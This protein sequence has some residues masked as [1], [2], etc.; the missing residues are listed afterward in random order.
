MKIAH[1]FFIITMIYS[2][3]PTYCYA[4]QTEQEGLD[5]Y[6][7]KFDECSCYKTSQKRN[8]CLTEL[9]KEYK[10]GKSEMK[11][12]SYTEQGSDE[13]DAR[14]TIELSSAFPLFQFYLIANVF[15]RD[16]DA[17]FLNKENELIDEPN[18]R[19]V[20]T[21][22]SYEDL[23]NGFVIWY[24]SL[25]EE[26]KIR[27]GTYYYNI[28]DSKREMYEIVKKYSKSETKEEIQKDNLEANKTIKALILSLQECIDKENVR[29]A[30]ETM[31]NN[32]DKCTCKLKSASLPLQGKFFYLTAF[33][34]QLYLDHTISDKSNPKQ[35]TIRR[36][37][38]LEKW[39]KYL[40]WY[41]SRT[42]HEKA[43]LGSLYKEY[44]SCALKFIQCNE[45]ETLKLSFYK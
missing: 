14:K 10:S 21:L 20:A 5:Y 1:L 28:I 7:K 38:A 34:E 15:M 25:S 6:L 39:H 36:K 8:A 27:L 30:L 37:N 42:D 17:Y 45:V 4:Q 24:K 3:I 22:T 2:F 32:Y 18:L 12:T 26:D 11:C 31:N 13:S 29:V 23:W 19:R 9:L 43:Y 40:E 41:T 44:N 33:I 16:D 35:A